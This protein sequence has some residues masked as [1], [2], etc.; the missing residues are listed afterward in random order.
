F[1]YTNGRA[2]Q[3]TLALGNDGNLY[4]TTIAGGGSDVG[5]VFKITTNGTLTSLVSF[6]GQHAAPLAG[7]ALGTD[8][9]FYGTTYL[10]G[11]INATYLN[12]NG[13]IFKVTPNGTLTTL[14]AFNYTN[15]ANP[16]AELTLGND[17]SFYG[18]TT[19]GGSSGY[20]TVFR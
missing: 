9:N 19:Y 15:G 4:G 13:T 11:N 18:T 16:Q 5:T 3:A 7:L 12:G 6:Q 8:G 17:G 2:P 10:G 14:V 1:A 20:G